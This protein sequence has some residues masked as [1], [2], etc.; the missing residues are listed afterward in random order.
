VGTP[1]A[2]PAHLRGVWAK[3][4]RAVEQLT[5]LNEEVLALGEEPHA[6]TIRS[7]TDHERGHYVFR[8]DPAWEASTAYRWGAII[9]EIVHD[10]RSALDQLVWQLVL[11]N[12]GTPDITHSFPI[13][14]G[15]PKGGFAKATRQQWTTKGGRQRHGPLSGISNNALTIIEEC[16]PYKRSDAVLL[17]KLHQLWNTDKHRH[18]V[19]M[20]MIAPNPTLKMTGVVLQERVPDR[21]DGNTYVVEVYGMA[22]GPDPYVDVEPHAPTDIAFHDGV[23]VVE[24]L[25]QIG[26]FVLLAI[27]LPA[28][29]LFPGLRGV[30]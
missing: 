10:L 20:H 23:A 12:G 24:G 5:T 22:V 4:N 2:Q 17:S 16:Q 7:Y 9:G 6:W 25:R 1:P 3:Y 11:L 30:G 8:L 15:E 28:S 27:L 26:K 13:H 14:R 19:P 18:L 21:F 29:E